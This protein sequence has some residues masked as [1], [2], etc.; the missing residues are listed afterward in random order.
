MMASL[1]DDPTWLS[2]VAGVP[3]AD[4]GE[5]REHLLWRERADKL[6]FIR[7][8]FVMF[9]VE[10]EFYADPDRDDLNSLWWDLVERLQLVNRPPGRHEQ[11]WV[12]K[13]HV[14]VAP[15]Y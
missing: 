15:V 13:I 4:L 7:C 14:A 12:A 8:A 10:R 2:E 5:A 11:D 3:E 9:N 6:I 1:A